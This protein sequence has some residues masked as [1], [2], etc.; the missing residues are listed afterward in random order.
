MHADNLIIMHLRGW[1]INIS[2]VCSNSHDFIPEVDPDPDPDPDADPN[3]DTDRDPDVDPDL[4]VSTCVYNHNYF[5]P[6][7]T[8]NLCIDIHVFRKI[9]TN[10]IAIPLQ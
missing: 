6:K 1:I 7:A 4:L 10:R 9:S 2:F 3:P 8:C 5:E